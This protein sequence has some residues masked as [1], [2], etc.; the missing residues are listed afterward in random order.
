[1]K[2]KR[3]FSRLFRWLVRAL[4]IAVALVGGYL[5]LILVTLPDTKPLGNTNP[6]QTR[7]MEHWAE[8]QQIP[9]YS[10]QGDWIPYDEFPSYL[11]WAFIE[12][13]DGFF[14]RTPRN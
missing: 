13:E 3:I 8:R 5:A 7:F 1:M 9:P 14:F 12:S 6:D 10:L 11:V 2:P 4:F